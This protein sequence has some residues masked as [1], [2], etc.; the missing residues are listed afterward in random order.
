MEYLKQLEENKLTRVK[1]HLST[2][3]LNG[4][5]VNYP[6]KRHKLTN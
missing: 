5:G 1:I 3:T 2:I 4:N 6:T